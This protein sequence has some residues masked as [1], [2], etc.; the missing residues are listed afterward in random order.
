MPIASRSVLA[1]ALS[2]II[3]FALG[4][5][6]GVA[7]I[8][9]LAGQI[10]L[11]VALV[12]VPL[13][14]LGTIPP[15]AY[16][17]AASVSPWLVKRL[18]IE[19]VAIAMALVG[20]VAHLWRGF[21]PTY[22]SLFVATVVVMLAAGVANVILPGLVKLYAPQ[23]IG[24]MTAGY[25]TAM[26]ISSSS[27]T[28]L[29][30]WVSE[31]WGWRV[32][33]ASWAIVSVLGAIPWLFVLPFA[34]QRG[35]AEAQALVDSGPARPP[36]RPWSSPTAVSIMLIFSVAGVSAYTW[37]GLLPVILVDISGLSVASAALALGLFAII[38]LPLSLIVP[39]LAVRPGWSPYLVAVATVCGVTGIAGLLVA[40]GWMPF[41]WVGFLGCA[42]MAFH[43][44]L[45]LIGKRTRDH[46]GALEVSGFVNTMGYLFAAAAPVLVG[47]VFEITGGWTL[48]LI[49]IGIV[50]LV[51]IPAIGILARE[52]IVE[53][54]AGVPA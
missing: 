25:A 31:E 50:M 27:P 26:A 10:E 18:G 45:T 30:L 16:A 12:G 39:P 21:S 29:G 1:L 54:E 11:D 17:V 5:R 32:S 43:L 13:G 40:P 14:A 46:R 22:L 19:W 20:A 41:L 47:F 44:S 52:A 38:G 9:P 15:I 36:L 28:V 48:A 24:P 35:V 8:A 6:T 2:G 34:R 7:A 3:L 49:G 42:P 53:D 51:Q 33:L 37:F 23:A 4:I